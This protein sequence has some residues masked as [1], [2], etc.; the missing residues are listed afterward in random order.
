[1][2]AILER[3]AGAPI[4][5]GVC[6]VP[7]WGAQLGPD[8][9]LSEMSALG[10]KVTEAGPVGYLGND[11]D[12]VVALLSRHGLRLVGG[13]VPVVLHDPAQLDGTLAG[14]RQ[15]ARLFEAAGAEF[16]VSAVVIDMDW[17]MPRALDRSEWKR[18]FDGFLRLD[19]MA[20][21]HG[22]THVVHPHWGTL[23]E[24]RD[25]VYRV[26][27]SS[28][29]LICLDTGHLALGETDPA[30]LA[31]DAA[32]RIAHVHLKDIS[33]ELAVLMRSREL[34]YV[35]AVQQGLFRQLG[36]G[37]ARVAESVY[38]LEHM[39]YDGWYVLEQDLSLASVDIARDA[40]PMT[41]V[42]RSIEFLRELAGERD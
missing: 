10:I 24:R 25:A 41:D 39:G 4:S 32:E 29:V 36:T 23:V 15:S 31:S 3:L 8:R 7:D 12:G 16:L 11:A 20:L 38:A 18:V 5:W 22:L 28:D 42:R 14:A 33:D 1:M 21:D 9:V 37:T 27:E 19:E 17:S 40:G 34:G 13:F 6:E 26:L 2:T 35:P 30:V